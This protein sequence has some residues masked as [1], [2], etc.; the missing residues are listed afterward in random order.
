MNIY[1]FWLRAFEDFNLMIARGA[2]DAE[3]RRLQDVVE[4]R[5]ARKL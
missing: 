3:F 1:E 5:R 2:N 4:K